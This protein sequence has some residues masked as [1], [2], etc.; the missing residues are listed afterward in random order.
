VLQASIYPDAAEIN[1]R[2]AGRGLSRQSWGIVG[3]IRE[4]DELLQREPSLRGQI[5]ECHPEVCFW[6]LNGNVAM[7]HNKK[8]LEGRSERIEV[9]RRHFAD[10][11]ALL[12]RASHE[13]RR[14]DLALDDVLDALVAAVTAKG[15]HGAYKTVPATP[16]RDSTGLPMEMVYWEF[17]TCMH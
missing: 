7:R 11:E 17:N 8:T 16:S 12:D 2:S 6:A 15:G 10:V 4:I 9:I 13:F 14:K 1:M 5:R 3:K